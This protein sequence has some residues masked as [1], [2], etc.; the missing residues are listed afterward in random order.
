MPSYKHATCQH[1]KTNG[2]RCGSPAQ[3][4]ER[5]CY[6]HLRC[7]TVRFN[8]GRSYRNYSTG[9]AFLPSFEDATSIQVTLHNVVELVM[10]KRMDIAEG[11]LV[12]YA[13]QIA[14]SNL[15]RLAAEK[16]RPGQIVVD[17]PFIPLT[18]SSGEV[19]AEPPSAASAKGEVPQDS[20]PTVPHK[21]SAAFDKSF[22]PDPKPES[23][24]DDSLP[25]GTIQACQSRNR[26][27]KREESSEFEVAALGKGRQPDTVDNGEWWS[28]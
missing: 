3:R 6:F 4:D 22:P 24:S 20:L 23:D 2:T 27:R 11:R 18:D 13:L 15:K 25:P 28:G 17:P 12:L 26:R 21:W 9:Q 5:F 14:S 16:P 1:V 19:E 8:Y 7:R 10:R